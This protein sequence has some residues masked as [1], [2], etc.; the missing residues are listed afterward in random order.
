M[1]PADRPRPPLDARQT[2]DPVSCE[3]CA[4][5]EQAITN[6]T[7]ETNQCLTAIRNY[8]AGA[9]HCMQSGDVTRLAHALE[10]IDGQIDRIHH[11]IA[12]ARTQP[13]PAAA[14]AQPSAPD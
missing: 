8:A 9:R 3:T 5:R 7:H 13:I 1:S 14:I 11:L 2:V 6:L 10:Q 12:A 4:E